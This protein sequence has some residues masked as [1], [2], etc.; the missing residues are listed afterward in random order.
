ME[1]KQ[2]PWHQ[3]ALGIA[4]S[5]LSNQLMPPTPQILPGAGKPSAGERRIKEKKKG[6]FELSRLQISPELSHLQ[7][8]SRVRWEPLWAQPCPAGLQLCCRGL[9]AALCL[10]LCYAGSAPSS[11]LHG[12]LYIQHV[13]TKAAQRA[14]HTSNACRTNPSTSP[15]AKAPRSP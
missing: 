8:S 5:A 13:Q 1:A 11:Q 10:E 6:N 14:A 7:H 2:V 4:C 15:A 3:A 9:S 12:L